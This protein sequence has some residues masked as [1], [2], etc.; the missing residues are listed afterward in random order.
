MQSQSERTA[1][2]IIWFLNDVC[3]IVKDYKVVKGCKI[4]KEYEDC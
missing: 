3:E 2:K 4:V 1:L